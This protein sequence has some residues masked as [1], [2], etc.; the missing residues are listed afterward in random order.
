MKTL[1]ILLAVAAV[2]GCNRY[3]LDNRGPDEY[4]VTAKPPLSLPPD[5]M[6]RAP[7]PEKKTAVPETPSAEEILSDKK[8][9]TNGEKEKSDGLSE[10]EKALLEAI[11]DSSVADIRERLENDVRAEKDDSLYLERKIKEWQAEDA[12]RLDAPKEAARLKESGVKT[13]GSAK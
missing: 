3:A 12:E 2:S 10:G 7:V 11:P 1:F 8:N 6:L 13:T 5:F 9:A 4:A